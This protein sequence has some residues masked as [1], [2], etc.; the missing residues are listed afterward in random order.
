MRSIQ[1]NFKPRFALCKQIMKEKES[2][3][4]WRGIKIQMEHCNGK[5][6]Y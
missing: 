3:R 1:Y 4:E 5:Q 2:M 6:T